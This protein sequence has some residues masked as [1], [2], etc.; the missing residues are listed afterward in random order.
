MSNNIVEAIDAISSEVATNGFQPSSNNVT[1]ALDNLSSILGSNKK[2]NNVVESLNYIKENIST[3]MSQQ[4]SNKTTNWDQVAN[5]LKNGNQ[6]KYSIGQVLMTTFKDPYSDKVLDNPLRIVDF[7]TEELENGD[8]VQGMWL[9]PDYAQLKIP[10]STFEGILICSEAI[11]PGNYYFAV[12]NAS[13]GYNLNSYFA[14][15]SFI[16]F[17][18]TKSV[19]VNGIIGAL[20]DADRNYQANSNNGPYYITTYEPDRKTVI[21]TVPVSKTSNNGTYLG[22]WNGAMGYVDPNPNLNSSVGI[23]RGFGNMIY[24][25]LNSDNPEG[26]WWTPETEWSIAPK[27]EVYNLPGYLSLLPEDLVSN[28][29]PVKIP[30]G[31]YNDP[32]FKYYKVVLPDKKQLYFAGSSFANMH[33]F[34][35][36]VENGGSNQPFETGHYWDYNSYAIPVHQRTSIFKPF[37]TV[38]WWIKQYGNISNIGTCDNGNGSPTAVDKYYGVYWDVMAVPIFFIG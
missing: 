24:Q 11:A 37:G 17:T 13:G 6:D 15:G 9:M 20:T 30:F 31:A 12:S 34:E 16:S 4:G 18:L 26:G 36:F 19:P 22:R 5:D 33:P 35:Y 8:Q 25:W 21:E 7:S 23:I 28:I 10:F 1:E 14:K 27:D 2:S 32:E 38:G 29:K 3:Y